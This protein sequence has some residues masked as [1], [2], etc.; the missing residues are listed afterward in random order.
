[1]AIF[2]QNGYFLAKMANFLPD[3][4]DHV[5]PHLDAVLGVVDARIRK[6][7]HAVVAIAQD[8]DSQAVVVLKRIKGLTT[9]NTNF[10]SPDV[11]QRRAT[12]IGLFLI[13]SRDGA[14][15]R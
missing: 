7:G 9:R 10:M 13:M 11:A 12:T 3:G 1:M 8:L 6:S 4:V 2:Y 14:Q 15:Q 5:E